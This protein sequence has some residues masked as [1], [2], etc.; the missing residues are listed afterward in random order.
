MVK[1]IESDLDFFPTLTV[2]SCIML[3][4][5][6]KHTPAIPE[7]NSAVPL[8]PKAMPRQ[9]AQQTCK[10]K[11]GNEERQLPIQTSSWLDDHCYK[12]L[13][14]RKTKSYRDLF[15]QKKNKPT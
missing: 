5:A 14:R 10:T 8:H 6:V 4:E 12:N 9:G 15:S 13:V 2:D 7:W 11:M 3:P 1:V